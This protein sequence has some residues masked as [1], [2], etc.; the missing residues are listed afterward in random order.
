[1]RGRNFLLSREVILGLAFT[2][3]L[4]VPFVVFGGNKV[5]FVDKSATGS[6]DGSST[7]PYQTIAKALDHVS[8]GTEVRVKNGTYKENIT[9]PKN[10]DL[11]GD[12]E[13]RD[14]VIIKA[15]NNDKPTVTMKSDT[16]LSHVTVRDGRHGVRI[17]EDAKAHIFDVVVEG[18]D[19]D[20]IHIDSGSRD[21]KHR[22]LIDKTVI[23]DNGRAGIFSEKRFI[24]LINSD[25]LSND[26]DGLDLAHGTEAWLENNRFNENKGSGAK[27]V[28]DDASIFG[29]KN[30][31][32]N[33]HRE[34]LEVNAFGTAGTIELKRS[35]FIGN[36]RNGVARVA[37]TIS[38][39]RLFGNL[40]FGVGI[41]ASRFENDG[42]SGVSPVVRSF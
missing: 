9:I 35:A 19:R 20:G 18:N 38:G 39:A 5:V 37:R 29:K 41:N 17:D 30:G 21:K 7:H 32:R 1:M 8:E 36:D 3:L 26:S 27:F 11:M 42:L 4:A 40:S 28:L 25:I 22:V 31:F 12:S 15:Q 24:V 6:E 14:K 10:V 2:A 13:K 33:N 16:A 34:G 23:Q